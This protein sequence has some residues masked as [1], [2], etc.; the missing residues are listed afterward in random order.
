MEKLWA[1][2][3]DVQVRFSPFIPQFIDKGVLDMDIINNIKCDKILVEFLRVNTW[4]RRWF[5]IDYTEYTY[6]QGSYL[7]LPLELKIKYL[8]L[9]NGF[10]EITVCED[11]DNA[12]RYWK[13]NVNHNSN[14]CCNL[15]VRGSD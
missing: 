7:H 10:K 6:K 11:E 2:G 13:E 1:N 8:K 4:I 9:I 12:Y 3:F 15:S 14:D 5:D